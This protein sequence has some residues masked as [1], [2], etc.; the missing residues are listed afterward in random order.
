[1][2]YWLFK[3]EPGTW[4][5]DD[6]AKQG[7]ASWDGVRNYAARNHL[8]AMKAGDLGFFYHSGAER[9]IVG[10][11]R[12]AA[13]AHPDTTTD[14]ERWVCVD[15]EAVK[16]VPKPVTL[17]AIKAETRLKDMALVRIG[18]L[19]VS[20]VTDAEWKRVCTLAG[21]EP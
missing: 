19:S 9:A 12:V 11:V 2:A 6:Q 7:V 3:S 14:D 18:R 21:L 17:E 10:I 13:E 16:K 1:M 20:P 15:I 8:R 4:S 5:F